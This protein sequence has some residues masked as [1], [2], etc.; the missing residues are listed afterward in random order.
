[1]GVEALATQTSRDRLKSAG[2]AHKGSRQVVVNKYK[3]HLSQR[4]EAEKCPEEDEE[5]GVTAL[6]SENPRI[7]MLDEEM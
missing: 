6:A 1:M 2:R 4:G 3:E 7:L 5:S